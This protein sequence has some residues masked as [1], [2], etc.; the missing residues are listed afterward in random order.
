MTLPDLTKSNV[1]ST[2]HSP[3]DS[4]HP[5]AQPMCRRHESRSTMTAEKSHQRMHCQPPQTLLLATKAVHDCH[6]VPLRDVQ[7]CRQ[8]A[9]TEQRALC[10]S[11]LQQSKLQPG[12]LRRML[13]GMTPGQIMCRHHPA[14]PDKHRLLLTAAG[15]RDTNKS[16]TAVTAHNRAVHR[17]ARS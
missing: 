11:N 9:S 7:R 12:V 1:A 5:A 6:C 16:T 13:R 14:A 4:R 3:A 15:K 2:K 17:Q 8:Q 10:R